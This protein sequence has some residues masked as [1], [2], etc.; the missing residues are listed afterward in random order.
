MP[1]RVN[2]ICARMPLLLGQLAAIMTIFC[3][4]CV[5]YAGGAH[6]R[7]QLAAADDVNRYRGKEGR[8]VG[9]GLRPK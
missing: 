3:A 2:A 4:L 8:E 1:R 9:E 7:N 6:G 5:E